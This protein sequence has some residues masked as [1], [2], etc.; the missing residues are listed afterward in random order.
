MSE[1]KEKIV[2]I[3]TA[4]GE[5]PERATFPFLLANAAQAMDVEAVIALQGSGVFLAKKDYAR[6]ISVPGLTPLKDMVES[7]VKNGGKLLVCIPCIE[8]RQIEESEL[9]EGAELAK[10]G[11]LIFE[12][13]S[14]N[15]T[16]VY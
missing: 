15:A 3:V 1:Q 7:F 6:H 9:I 10:A 4:A 14:A 11:K 16:L 5:H 13:T 12:I 8:G 2:Y